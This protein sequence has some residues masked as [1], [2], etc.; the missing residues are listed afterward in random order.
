MRPTLVSTS[1]AVIAALAVSGCTI[2]VK[3]T[4]GAEPKQQAAASPNTTSTTTSRRAARPSVKT[5]RA[6]TRPATSTTVGSSGDLAPRITSPIIFG[7][8]TGGA[9]TGHAYVIP[10]TTDTM[11]DLATLT[12]FATLFTDSFNVPSQRF[13]GG[14]PGA[15]VQEDFF[16]L[17]YDGSFTI[18]K[19]GVWK[20]KV[21]SDDGAILYI[22]GEKVVN[23]DGRHTVKTATGEKELRAGRHQ[24]RLD[25][26]QGPKG[27]VALVVHIVEDG[28]DKI[29]TGTK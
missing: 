14:F 21:A 16:A 27:T 2:T 6:G 20:F 23:N 10:D 15:L 5:T 3:S 9:F 29:L 7:N 8:G 4:G 17:R 26:F 19:D 18:P 11:P 13:S 24:L 12:P 1:I 25:Y 28:K 22:D